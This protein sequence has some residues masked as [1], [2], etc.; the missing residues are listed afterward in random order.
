MS[1]TRGGT[2]VLAGQVVKLAIQ[3]IGLVALARLLT[4]EDFGLI[5]MVAV[6]MAIADL[7]R[8][9]G[10]SAAALQAR[11]LSWQQASN[12]FWVNAGL[13]LSA[14]VAMAAVSPLLVAVFR[15]PRLY[16]IAPACA[17]PLFLN[18]LQVVVQVQLARRFKFASLMV[19]DVTAQLSALGL[20]V[21][22]ALAG[23][24]YW[25]L[26]VQM[27]TAATVLLVTRFFA[28]GWYP[29]RPRRGY[30]SMSLIRAGGDIGAAQAL[31]F[32]ASNADN[33]MVG[34]VWGATNLGYYANAFKLQATPIAGLMA[35]LTNVVIPVL[36]RAR[37]AGKDTFQLVL[38]LQ[39]VV[40]LAVA[41]LYAVGAASA[42]AII[43]IALGDG[44]APSVPIF[45][46]LCI[47]SSIQGLSFVNYWIYLH[48]GSTR[49]L[50]K[51]NLVTKPIS[52]AAIVGAAFVNPGAVAWAYGIGLAFT[53][54]FATWYMGRQTGWSV[55]QI[56]RSGAQILTVGW[57]SSAASYWC[58]AVLR[59]ASAGTSVLLGVCSTTLCLVALTAA[60]PGL[61][62]EISSLVRNTRL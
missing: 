3:L 32:A 21:C 39:V 37:N 30:N 15:E 52:V 36:N 28:A 6:V 54:V 26:I 25:A 31:N 8:D 47:G 10:M 56:Y 12:L 34:A 40:G 43:S 60:T 5:A 55:S 22:A 9:F 7:L 11:N 61:R 59:P 1:A 41:W 13:G 4:P 53:W 44:W 17:L 45:M 20:A 35:P 14:A 58:A 19:T 49:G 51:S 62:R 46:I 33:F 2:I 50:L 57:L 48:T 23:W 27:L 18:A 16:W 38:S 42:S 29:R 24:G